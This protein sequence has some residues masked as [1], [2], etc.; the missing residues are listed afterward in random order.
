MTVRSPLVAVAIEIE[1]STL[2][3]TS[4]PKPLLHPGA[5]PV[6]QSSKVHGFPMR[7]SWARVKLPRRILNAPLRTDRRPTTGNSQ[8]RNSVYT[9]PELKTSKRLYILVVDEPVASPKPELRKL[10]QYKYLQLVTVI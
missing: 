10:G 7:P 5:R 4:L 8:P 3:R 9:A 2:Q 1:S 6:T